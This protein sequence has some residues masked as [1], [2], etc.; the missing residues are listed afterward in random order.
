MPHALIKGTRLYYQDRGKGDP[1]VFL[2]CWATNSSLWRHQLEYFSKKNRCIATD[3]FGHGKTGGTYRSYHP[4]VFATHLHTLLN[5]LG[6]GKK[7]LVL[8]GHSLGGM[9]AMCYALKYPDQVRAMVLTDTTPGLMGFPEQG[10]AALLA[11]PFVLLSTPLFRGLAA[12][13]TAMHPFASPLKRIE[14]VWHTRQSSNL[15]TTRTLMDVTRFNV[16]RRLREID[17]PT[18]IING[19]LDV[20]TDIRHSLLLRLLL[21]NSTLEIVKFSGHT[22]PMENPDEFNRKMEKFI[23]NQ[24]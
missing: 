15:A 6:L 16:T 3:Y 14:M 24:E 12:A 20:Y 18:L 19:S 1:I 9:V 2:H 10:I 11:A 22:A 4:E 23:K 8:V 7:K 21:K 5:R 13:A 17:T